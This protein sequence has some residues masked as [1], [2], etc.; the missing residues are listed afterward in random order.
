MRYISLL[1]L[2]SLAVASCKKESSSGVSQ[3][4][5]LYQYSLPPG[6]DMPDA[7]NN[8]PTTWGKVALGKQLFFDPILSK[9]STIACASCH[10]QSLAFTD[11]ERF[12]LGVHDSIGFRNAPSLTNVAYNN[13]FFWDG[14][15]PSLELQVIAPI[16]SPFEMNN[17]LD[18]VIARLQ[19]H[20]YY[21]T[22]FEKVFGRAVDKSS[23]TQAIASF[24]RTLIS[25]NSPF[26][27]YYYYQENVLSTSEKRGLQLF[28]SNEL[29]CSSCHQ[30]PNFTNNGFANNGLYDEYT[31]MGRRRVTVRYNDDALFK[32]PT[33]RNIARTQP[34]M[35]DGSMNTLREVVQHYN[36]GGSAHFNKSPL[37]RPLD[38]SPED[39]DDLVAFLQALT[40]AS[41]LNDP[42]FQP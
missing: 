27:R 42:A 30:L 20:P 35:H 31:D 36:S 24:E 33:L 10:S 2:C 22:Q 13:L 16:E 3:L 21:S 34:Y 4:H 8:N 17:T 39:I 5:Q 23:F 15:V 7:P 1:L 32:I 28:F 25:F 40:D 29:S 14:G 38:L 12:S 41:F 37:V 11:K 6:V 19:A 26:D 18:T 9:D